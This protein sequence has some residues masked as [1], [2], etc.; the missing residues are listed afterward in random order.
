MMN[1]LAASELVL[2]ED[3]SVYHL[4][5]LPEDIAEKIILVGDPDRVPKVSQYF[6]KVEIKKNK[7]EFYTHTGTL[8]GERITVM[9]TGI[10]TENIDI[11]MNELDALVN[12]DLKE[13]EFKKEHSPLELFRLGTCGSVNPDVEVD[14]MLVTE[15]VVGLDGLLHFYQDYQFENEFSKNFLEKFPYLNIKPL[16]YFSDW[17]KESAHYY[18]DAKYIGNTATFPGFYAPQGRQLRLKA[19]DDQFLET[20]NDLGV[21]NFEMETSAIYGLSKLLGHKAITV[22]CVIANRRRGEFS[23]DHHASEKMTI[24]WVLDRI[25]K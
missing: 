20:L 5:L 3:G 10:G 7:R 11:V 4:N 16:L 23:A 18:Q 24:Q 21:T 1:K 14:N 19:L 12:I 17:A 9:S 13:K 22:N 8:R 2:N 15:N 25:I 6:D